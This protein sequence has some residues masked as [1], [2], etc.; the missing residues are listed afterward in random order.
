MT[1]NRKELIF[2]FVCRF[3]CFQCQSQPL[4]AGGERRVAFAESREHLVERVGQVPDLVR[5]VFGGPHRIVVTIRHRRRH[6]GQFK[7]W[8]R[9]S[10]LK[11]GGQCHGAKKRT[12]ADN[13]E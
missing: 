9:N 7:N 13:E 5:A 3:G 8:Q 12:D 10:V 4:F 2:L 6:F 11:R 1:D